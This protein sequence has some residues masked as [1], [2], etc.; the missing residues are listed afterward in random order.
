MLTDAYG[1]LSQSGGRNAGMHA[2]PDYTK[3]RKRLRDTVILG[4][5]VLFLSKRRTRRNAGLHVGIRYSQTIAQNSADWWEAF[6]RLR[7]FG[8]IFGRTRRLVVACTN[9]MS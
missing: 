5:K 9:R 4:Q 1:I 8:F 2:A 7:I 3:W 6:S